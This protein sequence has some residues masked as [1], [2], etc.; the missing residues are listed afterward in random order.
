MK[1]QASFFGLLIS[2][3]I[4]PAAAQSRNFSELFGE[5]K[6][7]QACSA[8]KGRC[9]SSCESKSMRSSLNIIIQKGRGNQTSFDLE[10][11][12]SYCKEKSTECEDRLDEEA[13]EAKRQV[14]EA[15]QLELENEADRKLRE[16]IRRSPSF[17]L[18]CGRFEITVWGNEGCGMRG[19]VNLSCL[20]TPGIISFTDGQFRHVI[21]RMTG[22][23]E[24]YRYSDERETIPCQKATPGSAK[25]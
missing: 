15:R 19:G 12:Y 18:A 8:L 9:D 14:K 13:E 20:V 22:L 25:F 23:L 3:L 2:L 5:A 4:E 21:N 11:C 16:S 24:R 17:I 6:S 1:F 10:E 7:K